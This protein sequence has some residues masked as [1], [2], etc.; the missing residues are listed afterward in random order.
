MITFPINVL[1]AEAVG[2]KSVARTADHATILLAK[3]ILGRL[4][5]YEAGSREIF[6][7]VQA[8]MPWQKQFHT[9]RSN[10]LVLGFLATSEEPCRRY[11]PER[12]AA[13]LAERY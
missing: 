7:P 4:A 1:L 3:R 2:G 9:E 5:A 6:S 11:F 8:A 13:K 10:I 12:E